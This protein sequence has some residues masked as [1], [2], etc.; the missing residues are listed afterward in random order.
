[1]WANCVAVTEGQAYDFGAWYFMQI[2]Q[3]GSGS[4]RVALQWRES[5]GGAF[6]GGDAEVASTTEGV[7]TQIAGRAV[8]PAG[9]GSARIQ[10]VN[11]K[12]T[13]AQGEEREVHFDA[14]FLPEPGGA[15]FGLTVLVTLTLLQRWRSRGC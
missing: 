15:A 10:L 3:P 1:M 5:C 6:I 4:A 8:A 2:F 13:G 12:S 9:A 14:V 11:T 7:W